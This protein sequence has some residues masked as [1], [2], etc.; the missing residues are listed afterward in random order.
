MEQSGKGALWI[1]K[2]RAKHNSPDLTGTVTIDGR[3]YFVSAWHSHGG[4][5]SPNFNLSLSPYVEGS[6]TKAE[7]KVAAYVAPTYSEVNGVDDDL[8]F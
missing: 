1:N 7:A 5:G 8:P 2:R 6:Q 3:K 4:G